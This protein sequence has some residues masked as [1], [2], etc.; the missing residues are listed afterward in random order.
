MLLGYAFF[1]SLIITQGFFYQIYK[2]H[3]YKKIFLFMSFF[4]LWLLATFRAP[5]FITDDFGYLEI[6]YSLSSC[7]VEWGYCQ[8][9][10]FVHLLGNEQYILFGILAL[11]LFIGIAIF[12][13][14]YSYSVLL[15]TL[16]YI[17][18][19]YAFN[20]VNGIRQFIA[21]AIIFIFFPSVQKRQFIKFFIVIMFA[22]LFHKSAIICLSFYWL[23]EMEV[24]FKNIFLIVTSSFIFCLFFEQFSSLYVSFG[25][26][27]ANYISGEV[28]QGRLSVIIRFIVNLSIAICCL[29]AYKKNKNI[30]NTKGHIPFNF[31]TICACISAA[32]AL[33]ALKAYMAERIV[34]YFYFFNIITIPNMLQQI[35]N[36]PLK[37]LVSLLVLLCLISYGAVVL[38]SWEQK[39]IIYKFFWQ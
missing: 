39:G 18:L 21:L 16:V 9:N 17:C 25:G 13:Y 24:N 3:S 6:F 1:I 28:E 26:N 35:H 36:K 10:N 20:S 15:S 2:S 30:S 7:Y 4:E 37:G 12:I 27:Y 22:C 31:L 19:M 34:Y 5:T 32:G 29:I 11:L 14:R 38:W 33:I 23:Y 8:L